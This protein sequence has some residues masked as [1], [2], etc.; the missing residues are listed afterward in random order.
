MPSRSTW[1]GR[2]PGT[3]EGRVR[4]SVMALQHKHGGRSGKARWAPNSTVGGVRFLGPLL[5]GPNRWHRGQVGRRRSAKPQRLGSIPS[6]ASKA[7]GPNR[8]SREGCV[9]MPGRSFKPAGR[10]APPAPKQPSAAWQV[11][12]DCMRPGREQ[13]GGTGGSIPGWG[14]AP[15]VKEEIALAS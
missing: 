8:R 10:C 14:D 3:R 9:R 4:F 1:S 7:R 5:D 12:Q 15:M 6:G 2:S 11:I 13:T